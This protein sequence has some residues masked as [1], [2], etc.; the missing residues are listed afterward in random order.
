MTDLLE[1][2]AELVDIPSVSHHEAA[3]T[4]VIEERLRTSAHLEVERVGDNVVARTHLRRAQRVILGGHTDTVPVNDNDRARLDGDVLWGL[5][6]ADM[7]SGL[8]VM[9]ALAA[10]V[11]DPAV[12]VTY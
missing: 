12:D 4:D 8:A 3:I 1:A 11:R 7:K 5:G 9:L 6:S 2:T 10:D